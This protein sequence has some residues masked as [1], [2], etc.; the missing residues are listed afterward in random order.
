MTWKR[1]RFL[2]LG[3][4]IH[5]AE[6]GRRWNNILDTDK[7]G[8][9]ELSEFVEAMPKI[10]YEGDAKKLFEYLKRDHTKPC[11]LPMLQFLS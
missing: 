8:R 1:D 5:V 6:R 9:L 2:E 11:P 10:G 7:S 3:F 4:H